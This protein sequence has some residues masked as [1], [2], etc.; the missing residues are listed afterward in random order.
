MGKPI[1]TPTSLSEV[2]TVCLIHNGFSCPSEKDY[3]YLLQ[4]INGMMSLALCS[5]VVSQAPQHFRSSE[6]EATC[7]DCFAH[8][9][10]CSVISLHS[11]SRTVHPQESL[12]VN[13]KHSTLGEPQAKAFLLRNGHCYCTKHTHTQSKTEIYERNRK[14]RTSNRE[15][16]RSGR[17]WKHTRTHHLPDERLSNVTFTLVLSLAMH[18]HLWW[19]IHHSTFF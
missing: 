13:A 15:N 12:M 10:I 8:Q 6:I 17:R 16:G 4:I 3:A 5:Q 11:M 7:D 18:R 9:S 2:S 19:T 1:C 14:R